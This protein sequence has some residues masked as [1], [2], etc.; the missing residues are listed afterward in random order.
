[1]E[2]ESVTQKYL[3]HPRSLALAFIFPDPHQHP[4]SP[5]QAMIKSWGTID[6]DAS[7]TRGNDG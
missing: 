5:S 1:M 2:D 7:L 3:Y 6:G 4:L